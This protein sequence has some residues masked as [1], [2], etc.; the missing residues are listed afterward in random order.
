VVSYIGVYLRDQIELTDRLNLSLAV[1]R[2]WID[3]DSLVVRD[4]R[5]NSTRSMVTIDSRQEYS[6][7]TS[8]IGLI[9]EWL[10]GI[11][12]YASYADSF[13]VEGGTTVD[14]DTIKP[15]TGNQTEVG[16]K[17]SLLGGRMQAT[18]AHFDLTRKN[19]RISDG[20]NVG[21]YRQIGE[22]RT[23]GYEFEAKA[24]L[25]E[26]WNLTASYANTDGEIVRDDD[27]SKV[28]GAL[29]NVPRHAASLW[30]QYRVRSGKWT[31]LGLGG[32]L[33]YESEKQGYT[34]T[35]YSVPDYTVFDASV[36]YIGEGYRFNLIVK[37]LFDRD[38]FAG[39][40]NNNV[41]ALGDPRRILAT[42]TLDL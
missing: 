35:N 29:E 22:Q 24:D 20:A 18:A 11:S 32:G 33:R 1:R 4:I 17:L 25:S 19:P 39:G 37:N 15:E 21:F 2:D 26:G 23:R 34:Y 12:P 41:I 40:L 27:A 13:R 36:S 16:V 8:S 31:G 7:T 3:F 9:Y 42:V 5:T 10:P 6:A 38:Y 30:A 28:G 14:G